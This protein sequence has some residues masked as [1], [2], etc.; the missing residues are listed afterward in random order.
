[1]N[2]KR[3]LIGVTGGIA[4]YKICTLV[5]LLKKEGAEVKCVLTPSAK[6]FVSPLT[7]STLSAYP[8]Y[9]NFWN[10]ENGEWNSHVELGLWADL[11][12]I[13]PLTANTLAKLANGYC[14]NL[15][16]ACYLSCKAPVIVS[17]AMDLDMYEHKTTKKNID[18]LID[19]GVKV[20]ESEYGELAS[21]LIGHG[22]L[23]EP[24]S[25]LKEVQSFFKNSNRFIGKKVLITAGPSYEKIDPVRFIGNRS[26]GKMGF[27]IAAAL[28][29]QGAEVVLLA[30]PNKEHLSHKN[31]KIITFESTEDLL[32][33]VQLYWHQMDIGIFSAAV[34]D[35]KV[36]ETYAQKVKKSSE[37]W[38]ITLIKNPDTLAWAG[39]HKKETQFLVGFALET[40][41]E[42]ENAQK[43]L[44]KKNLDLI[45]LNSLQ[46][47]GAGFQ[48]DTNQISIINKE[49][50][51]INFPLKS[52]KEVAEDIISCIYKNI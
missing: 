44:H 23:P 6:D 16:T 7:L 10:K 11:M 30:G 20:I 1:M 48:H 17:P 25:L 35:Y 28:L 27:Q 19:N 2:G 15:L 40:E 26:S 42:I 47:K 13:A 8:C 9:I 52:K 49:G 21:G 39:E 24:E 36:K 51:Q 3:I 38:T 50:E 5:R 12:L 31:L 18:K 33:S 43:K 32:K 45:I 46:N 4:A 29:N 41:N 34:A 22:R 14:D 37:E